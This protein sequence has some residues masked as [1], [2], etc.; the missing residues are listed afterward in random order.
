MLRDST[1][2]EGRRT[3]GEELGIDYLSQVPSKTLW[4]KH[5]H[6]MGLSGLACLCADYSKLP[7]K[8]GLRSGFHRISS[9]RRTAARDLSG[10][11]LISCTKR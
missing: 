3:G 7:S 4:E 9:T 2:P 5:H 10:F 6:S 8:S 11:F 1:T